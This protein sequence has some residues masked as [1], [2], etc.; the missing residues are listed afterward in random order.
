MGR[1]LGHANSSRWYLDRLMADRAM[2]VPAGSVVLDAGAG[3]CPYRPHF[4]HTRYETADFCQVDKK[5]GQI[6]YVCKLDAI[7]VGAARYDYVLCT[8]VLE[9]LPDPA[10]VLR[11]FHRILK[12]G[13]LLYLTA[14]LYYEEHEKPY[15]FYRYTQFGLQHL[16]C[17]AGYQVEAIDWL[18]G[19]YG[20]LAHQFGKAGRWLSRHPADYGGGVIGLAAAA[21]S[22]LLKPPLSLLGR[23]FE[24]LDVRHKFTAKGHCINY[25]LVARRLPAT[26]A[27]AA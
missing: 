1:V 18:E 13:G 17:T 19:Y 27:C 26:A 2:G 25:A 22:T 4:A 15:D 23:W 9:H 8:Q 10:A 24:R 11:E 21:V 3:H 20:T 16:L 7:P 14:P 5:Y 6:D 12:P